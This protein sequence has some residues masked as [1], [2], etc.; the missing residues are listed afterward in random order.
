[1]KGADNEGLFHNSY[2]QVK[3]RANKNLANNKGLTRWQLT[4]RPEDFGFNWNLFQ[5]YCHKRNFLWY[6][7][8]KNG[9]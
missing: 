9:S 8:C 4:P 7:L 5:N 1:M 6:L 2:D 3:D